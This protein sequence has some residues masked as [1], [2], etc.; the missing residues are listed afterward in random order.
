[1]MQTIDDLEISYAEY[2]KPEARPSRSL[3]ERLEQK[4]YIVI[5][6]VFL[7]AFG[8]RVYRLGAASFAE[9]ETNKI[10]ALRAYEQGDL[11]VNAEH[12]MLMKMLCYVSV[13]ASAAWNRL[14]GYRLGF[15]IS[16][17]AALRLPNAT[18]GALTVVPLF[19]LTY[20]LLGFRIGLITSLLWATGLNAIWFNR[21]VKE[22]TLLIFFMITGLYIYNRAKGAD[23]SNPGLEEKLYAISGAA[24]GLMMCSKYF[25][26]YYGLNVLFYYLTGYDGRNNRPMSRRLKAVHFGAMLLAFVLFNPVVFLPQTWRY[27]WAYV[28]E[29]LLTHHGYLIMNM[30]YANEAGAMPFGTPWYT[31]YLYLAVKVPVPLIFAFLVG[32]VEIFRHR[33]TY[34]D[35]R[36]YLFLRVML[37]F[38]LFPMALVG[39][40]FL[41]YTLSLMPMLYM[42]AAIGMV[43]MWRLV[44]KAVQKT[45]L[46][47]RAAHAMA[48]V[49]IVAVFLVAPAVSLARN[50]PYPSLYLNIF[51][52]GKVGYY[53]PHDE[54]YDLGARE[55]IKHIAETA[56]PG[57]VVATEIPGVLQYYL[58][59]YNRP[60]IR[61]EIISHPEF[62]LDRTRPDF[63]LLQRG[64]TYFENQ[65][66]FSFIERNFATVQ[67]SEFEG[68]TATQLYKVGGQ[69]TEKASNRDKQGIIIEH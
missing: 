10:F 33:G 40:K 32:L 26:H 30:L 8:A 2:K 61:S 47:Q 34:P 53:F 51:G 50:M 16:E 3:L 55:S 45:S 22:D 42:T 58:E 41:R 15:E 14:A 37:V 46:N 65:D 6:M 56:P 12:P 17:E 7:L 62:S 59:R 35:S 63:V 31:Y 69:L 11:T 25:P 38:W 39:A 54:F 13:H 49:A 23:A 1:M 18:F 5:A 64:R 28:N 20:A 27:L 67:A 4:K 44:A 48:T 21:I 60:D 66:E 68:A 24:F 52:G 43:I 9:D 36:A 57:A 19:F 29:D